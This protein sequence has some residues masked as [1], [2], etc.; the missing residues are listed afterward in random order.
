MRVFL[1]F[2]KLFILLR[3]ANVRRLRS[4]YIDLR[5]KIAT[6]TAFAMLARRKNLS[7][8]GARF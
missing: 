6:G 7:T 1:I 2:W 5:P 3:T 4:K 8:E